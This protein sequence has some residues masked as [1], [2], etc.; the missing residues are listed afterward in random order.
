MSEEIPLASL[1][2]NPY[3]VRQ[4]YDESETTALA[5]SI[6][7]NGLLTPIKVRKLDGGRFQIV[8]GHR[9]VR[10]S[11]LLGHHTIKVEAVSLSDEEMLSF[12]LVENL[13]RKNL[14]DYETALSFERMNRVFR[15]SYEEIGKITGYSKSHIANYMRML[16]LFD[17]ETLVKNPNLKKDLACITEHHSRV[18]LRIPDPAARAS[19]LRLV[20]AENLSVREL[21][22][23]VLRLR[24]WFDSKRKIGGAS[25]DLIEQRAREDSTGIMPSG[26]EKHED[27]RDQTIPSTG[28]ARL[29][30]IMQIQS[31][32]NNIFTILPYQGNFEAFADL[33]AFESDFSIYSFFPPLQRLEKSNAIQKEQEWFYNVAPSLKVEIQDLRIQFFNDVALAT[34]CVNY[35]DRGDQTGVNWMIRGTVVLVRKPVSWKIVHEHWSPLESDRSKAAM[36]QDHP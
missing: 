23:A 5:R 22:T 18:L 21:E 25:N 3:N 7:E 20:V 6:K 4:D 36:V 10:A 26:A 11:R 29:G 28:H 17:D 12:S 1:E 15:K 30:D 35:R 14:S 32:L 33:H 24:G 34:L 2:D 27:S 9:R 19:A 13:M 31:I 8:Y 16:Q